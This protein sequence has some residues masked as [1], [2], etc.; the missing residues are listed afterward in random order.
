MLIP[1]L[2]GTI[3]PI[4]DNAGGIA[5]MAGMPHDIRDNTDA[6]DAAGN[7]TAAIGKGFAIGSAALVSLALFGAFV[8]TVGL[9]TVDILQ[10]FQFA[11]LLVGAMLPYWFSAMTMKAVGEAALALVEEVR[12]LFNTVPLD[13]KG[14]KDFSSY[15][16]DYALCV[17]IST[18]A[19]IY[20]MYMYHRITCHFLTLALLNMHM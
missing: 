12:R 5:E 3:G 1:Y 11:G 7:T 8:T 16:P 18:Q 15:R 2:T 6:L 19:A 17:E 13:N 10:P 14:N 4:C 20:S 9:E